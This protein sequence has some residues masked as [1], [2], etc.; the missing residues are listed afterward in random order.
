M[1]TQPALGR[2]LRALREKDGRSIEAL[3]HAAGITYS[4]LQAIETGLRMPDLATALALVDALGLSV[5]DVLADEGTLLFA[6]ASRRKPLKRRK[7]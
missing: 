1:L 2:R 6:R 7:P 4:T 5:Y 3:A